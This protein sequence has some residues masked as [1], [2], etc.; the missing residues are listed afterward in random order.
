MI[1]QRVIH[2]G[3]PWWLPWAAFLAGGALGFAFGLAAVIIR[4]A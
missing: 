4:A 2:H 3:A 1:C